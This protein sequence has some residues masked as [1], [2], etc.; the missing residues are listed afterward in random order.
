MAISAVRKAWG[1]KPRIWKIW[2][3]R[4]RLNSSPLPPAGLAG[5]SPFLGIGR[6][7]KSGVM[8]RGQPQIGWARSNLTA[9][10]SPLLFSNLYP[11]FRLARS[12]DGLTGGGLTVPF[13]VTPARGPSHSPR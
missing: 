9:T 11:I 4:E 10:T 7:P 5:I 2:L 1:T 8:F 3:T 6:R 13:D 12:N